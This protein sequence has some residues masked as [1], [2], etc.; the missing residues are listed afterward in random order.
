MEIS[1]I[2]IYALIL[3]LMFGGL[4]FTALFNVI[5]PPSLK[6][7]KEPKDFPFISVLI[8]ARNEEQNIKT[9]LES[10]AKQNY[11]NFEILVLDDNSTDKTKTV[12]E[13]FTFNEPKV[14]LINGKELPLGWL[15]KNWACQQL[16]EKA[17]GEILIFTDADTKHSPNA[18]L[19]TI[20][21]IE[22]LDLGVLSTFPQ[23]ITKTFWEKLIVPVIDV[24]VYGMLPMWL[25]YYSKSPLFAAANGQWIAIKRGSYTKIGEHQSVRNKIV[26]DVELSRIAKTKGIKTLLTSGTDSIFCRMYKSK[27]EIWEGFSKNL[28]GITGSNSFVFWFLILL[29]LNA[30]ILPFL[31]FPFSGLFLILIFLNIVFRALI[32]LKFKHSF[33]ESVIL[34][35]FGILAIS[36]IGINSF[37]KT[38]FGKVSWKGR[39]IDLKLEDKN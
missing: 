30:C 28:F 32:A 29:L 19:Q 15:G 9:C 20:G 39:S 33:F 17:K 2:E 6:N 25:T 8:P 11:P 4:F 10:L 21:W 37:F 22:K 13:N 27:E 14:K 12:V 23:Q 18:V 3:M 5:F 36:V 7:A 16:G 35:P 24:F 34:H 1:G 26:E 38:K 31:L